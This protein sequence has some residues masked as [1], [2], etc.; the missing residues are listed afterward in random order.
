MHEYKNRG[1]AYHL[2]FVVAEAIAIARTLRRASI[3]I[4]KL[5]SRVYSPMFAHDVHND[6]CA[7]GV[8]MELRD[9]KRVNVFKWRSRAARRV[10]SLRSFF[11]V[12]EKCLQFT[13]FFYV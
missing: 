9:K 3:N 4:A 12:S 13:L 10:L 1:Q 6:R 5:L 11:S 2:S 8:I 7:R